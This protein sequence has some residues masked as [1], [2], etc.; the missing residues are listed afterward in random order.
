MTALPDP[1]IFI[2]W[3]VQLAVLAWYG[4]PAFRE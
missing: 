2:H 4:W 1:A 3:A